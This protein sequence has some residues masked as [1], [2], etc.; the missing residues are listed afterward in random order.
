MLAPSLSTD[1]LVLTPLTTGELQAVHALW[2]QPL[3]RRYL[4]D[5]EVIGVERAAEP[6]RA[7]ERDFR[8]HGFGLWGMYPRHS[9]ELVG[10]CGLRR[11]ELF[12]E[13][14][15]L[16]GVADQWRRHG[17]AGESA[18]GVLA[19][20]FEQREIER[21][22]AATDSPNLES[23]RLLERLGM[24]LVRRADHDG[25]DTLFYGLTRA[26]WTAVG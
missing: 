14:E 20:A 3:V 15:L 26:D 10:F 23:R 22:G 16:F 18:A 25:R 13:P 1:R 7:S 24:R 17:F 9:Q 19:Y 5:D 6:L 2:T 8:D 11:G 12:P 21:I 4:W